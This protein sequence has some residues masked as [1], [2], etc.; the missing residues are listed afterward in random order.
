MKKKR[1]ILLFSLPL[2]SLVLYL[3]ALSSLFFHIE[4][5][6]TLCHAFMCICIFINMLLFIYYK[7]VE[8]IY[9]D[10]S[11]VRKIVICFFKS[12]LRNMISGFTFFY[13]KT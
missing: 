2:I 9:S 7:Y 13:I 10:L 6:S 12:I 8:K 1:G 5:P 11:P 4:P 3:L